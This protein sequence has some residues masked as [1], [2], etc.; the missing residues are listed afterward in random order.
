MPLAAMLAASASMVA[1]LCGVFLA[2]RGDFLSLPSGMKT[3]APLVTTASGAFASAPAAPDSMFANTSAAAGATDL[4]FFAV[5]AI[6]LILSLSIDAG[7]MSPTCFPGARERA[8]ERGATAGERG[9][10]ALRA[11]RFGRVGT[12]TAMRRLASTRPG[13]RAGGGRG[14]ER[15]KTISPSW[16]FG[17]L[18]DRTPFF[19]SGMG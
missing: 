17:F 16:Q 7:G 4:A 1:S 19:S 9:R 8:A 3:P 6:V 13:P 15:A 18:P 14:G 10:A 11:G 12:M 2:L 5:P